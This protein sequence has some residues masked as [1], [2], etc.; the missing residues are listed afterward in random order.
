MVDMDTILFLSFS[1]L[2]GFVTS[3]IIGKV[4]LPIL[5]GLKARQEVREEGPEAHKS[6]S[7]TPT[8]GGWFFILA[9]LLSLFILSASKTVIGFIGDSFSLG[10]SFFFLLS[11]LLFYAMIGFIDDFLKVVLKQNLGLRAWQK[12]VLQIVVVSFLV[13]FFQNLIKDTEVAR[14]IVILQWVIQVPFWVYVPF[15]VLIFLGTTNATNVTDGLD[16]LLSG[17]AAISFVAF[18]FIALMQNKIGVAIFCLV[19]S[20]ALL[21]FLLYNKYPAKVFMGDTGSLAIGG[22]LAAVAVVLH[23]EFLLVIIGGVYVFET[24]SVLLQVVYFKY[25]K[26]RYGEGRRIFLMSPFHHHL[27]L[28]GWNE[29]KIVRVFYIVCT[30]CTVVGV[31]LAYFSNFNI[32]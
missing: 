31:V 24:L 16:G 5:K 15:V 9:T 21:G 4:G 8:M 13:I 19:L 17:C 23:A 11:G 20:G 28:K 18:A 25:T 12:L 6:K 27:E 1:V 29:Q 30:G 14:D 7:G 26:K 2:L 10:D 22:L 32:Y 3:A